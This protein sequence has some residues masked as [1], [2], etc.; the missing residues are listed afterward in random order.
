MNYKKYN[1]F[2]KFS[3]E[4]SY[5]NKNKIVNYFE[6]EYKYH[7][8]N[9][10][11]KTGLNL[12]GEIFIV[13]KVVIPK[14]ATVLL[15]EKLYI[16]QES[17]FFKNSNNILKINIQDKSFLLEVEDKFDDFAIFYVSEILMRYY[18]TSYNIVF[19]HASSFKYKDKSYII[20]SFG[21]TGKTNLL[22][23]ALTNNGIYLSDDLTAIDKNGNIYPYLKRINLLYYNFDYKNSLIEKLNLSI[24]KMKIINFINKINKNSYLYKLIIF[25]IEWKLKNNLNV[26]TDYKLISG[27]E[28][29]KSTYKCDKF[30]WLERTEHVTEKFS[31]DMDYIKDRMHLCLELENT[32]FLDFDRFFNL[33]SPK[34]YKLK[35]KQTDIINGLSQNNNFIP[36]KKKTNDELGLFNLI[37]KI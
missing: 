12:I 14:D 27:N 13:K 31:I 36:L 6:A 26:K 2:D 19:I 30:I 23:D 21:G 5:S 1:F 15:N 9:E 22:L 33:L 4:I 20:N 8:D 18:A 29:L 3:L 37:K 11:L 10:K 34:F 16:H 24:N 7:K 28:T 32:S 25:R 17:I 35:Q